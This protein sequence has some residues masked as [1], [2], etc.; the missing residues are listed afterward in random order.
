MNKILVISYNEGEQS[1]DQK[2]VFTFYKNLITSIEM[3]K[4]IIVCTQKSK[5]QGSPTHFQHIFKELIQYD[6]DCLYKED[7]STSL[8][9]LTENNNVRT[10]IYQYNKD[11]NKVLNK[12]NI[13]TELSKNTIG[14]LQMSVNRQAIYNEIIVNGKKIILINTELASYKNGDLGLSDRQKEFM[15]LIKEFKL[16]QKYKNGFNII[17]C[18]S[19]NFILN[20]IKIMNNNTKEILYEELKKY[21]IKK[22]ESVNNKNNLL[23]MNELKVYINNLIKKLENS[24]E[25]NVENIIINQIKN[26]NQAKL[27]EMKD[28]Y[29][30]LLIKFS[31]SIKDSGLKLTC[32]YNLNQKNYRVVSPLKLGSLYKGVYNVVATSSTKPISNGQLPLNKRQKLNFKIPSMCDKILFALQDN[33]NNSLKFEKFNIYND[34]K[35]S[36]NRIIY[37]IFE[38]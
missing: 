7:P 12:N 37:S 31:D 24:K 32:D 35:K 29:I 17:F 33:N 10:R 21:I 1:F 14:L 18:G 23:E 22:Y 36:K 19:L 8:V 27:R 25:N 16:H 5:S 15:G 34:L 2:E 9:G 3:P 13:K 6:Y 26:E 28:L 20:P 11:E 38:F 4:I 30:N